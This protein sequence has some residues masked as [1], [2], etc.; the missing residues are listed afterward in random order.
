MD[1][2]S[3]GFS[4]DVV[5]ALLDIDSIPTTEPNAVPGAPSPQFIVSPSQ[6]AEL[7]KIINTL[8]E[9]N[10]NELMSMINDDK[11]QLSLLLNNAER[12][13]HNCICR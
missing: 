13:L 7:I 12:V 9:V 3:F 6:K 5:N 1:I 10:E 4:P 2:E 8:N 11:W